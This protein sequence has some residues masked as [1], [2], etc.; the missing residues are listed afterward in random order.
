M[1]S[2][3]RTVPPG[4][5]GKITLTVNTKGYS[6]E[7]HKAALVHTN[8]PKMQR[9]QI[10]VKAFVQVPI[11]ISS[12]NVFLRPRGDEADAKTVKIEAGFEKPLVIEPEEFNL[13][14]KIAYEIKEVIKSR[15]YVIT[16]TTLPKIKGMVDGFLKLKTNYEETPTVK[17]RIRSLILRERTK[18]GK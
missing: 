13:E 3:D 14:G 9:V 6:G 16:F 10:G 7:I 11:L 5:E 15:S 1:A 8:D 4:G 17:I 12:Q 2:F 18:D